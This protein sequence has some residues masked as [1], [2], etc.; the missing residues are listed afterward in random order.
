[1]I[2][3]T[4][5][6]WD[7][8]PLPKRYMD[9]KK[10]KEEEEKVKPCLKTQV[11]GFFNLSLDQFLPLCIIKI[12]CSLSPKSNSIKESLWSAKLSYRKSF[13]SCDGSWFSHYLAR[14]RNEILIEP[15][16]ARLPFMSCRRWE[17]WYLDGES[18]RVCVRGGWME[19]GAACDT[20]LSSFL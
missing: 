1:M 8:T 2:K 11:K 16:T 6:K 3:A 7:T 14:T 5:I 13:P 4:S 9:S 10:K 18:V 20:L 17:L 15:E 12:R 19:S